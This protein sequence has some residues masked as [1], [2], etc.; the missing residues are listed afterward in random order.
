MLII[1]AVFHTPQYSEGQVP[2]QENTL[3]LSMGFQTYFGDGEERTTTCSK[4]KYITHIST[5]GIN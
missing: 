4:G 3:N 5:R 2:F 1:S